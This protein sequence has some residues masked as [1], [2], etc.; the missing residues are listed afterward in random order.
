MTTI[1]IE[2]SPSNYLEQLLNQAAVDAE[3]R[4]ELLKNPE[5]F[6]LSSDTE[7]AI[8]TSVEQ[9]DESFFEWFDD[10]LGELNIAAQCGTSCNKGPITIVCDGNTTK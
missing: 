8:P 2:H 9:Q 7:L 4:S 3:F 10:A 5:A 6:G 1:L